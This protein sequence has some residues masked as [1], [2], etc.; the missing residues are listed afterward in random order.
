MTIE[1]FV[2]ARQMRVAQVVC[3]STL[4]M[5]KLMN[6]ASPLKSFRHKDKYLRAPKKRM[7]KKQALASLN[8][9]K[10]MAAMD[11]ATILSQPFPRFPKCG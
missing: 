5:I 8:V 9:T 4:E 11:I 10:A 6:T 3:K 2:Y 1:E 7:A